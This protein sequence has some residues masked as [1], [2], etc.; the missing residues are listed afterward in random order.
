MSQIL[1]VAHGKPAPPPIAAQAVYLHPGQLVM[2]EQPTIVTTILGSCVSL[3]MRDRR[4]GRSAINHYL[5][6]ADAA[7]PASAL[8]TRYGDAAND[9]LLSRMLCAGS[10]P[11]DL[12]VKVF[13]GAC[14]LEA[15]AAG[16][17]HLG[18]RNVAAALD[19]L[20]RHHITL[21]SQDTG[22]RRGRKLIYHTASGH[23][24]VR[25]L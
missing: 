6:P 24:L 5:L 16:T 18:A 21:D 7:R 15:F 25:A 3:C 19:F 4:L 22:G 20:A 14:V 9:A 1:A 11:E 2:T 10:R 8:P 13:G 23:A 12:E 17:D